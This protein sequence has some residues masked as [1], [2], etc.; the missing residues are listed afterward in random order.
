MAVGS[1]ARVAAS[2][3]VALGSAM[4]L[5]GI[6]LGETSMPSVGLADGVGV[7]AGLQ[8]ENKRTRGSKTVTKRGMNFL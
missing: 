8:A 4:A 6:G 1:G 2:G 7:E 5:G 3:W